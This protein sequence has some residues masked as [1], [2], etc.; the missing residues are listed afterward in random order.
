MPYKCI[1][2]VGT[3]F[4]YNNPDHIKNWDKDWYYEEDPTKH[5]EPTDVHGATTMSATG[6]TPA[7]PEFKT[8]RSTIGKKVNFAKNYGAQK[9]R[10]RQM[11]P[12]CTEAEVAKIDA[13]YYN[14][15]PG[16][17][18]YHNYCYGRANMYSYTENLFGVKYYG[19]N[20]HKLINSLVQGS[21]AFYLKKKIR[22]VYDY[23]KINKIQST[24]QMNIHDELSWEVFDG[25]EPN[26]FEIKRIMEDWTDA[27][28]PIVA[29][30]DITNKT[31][32]DKKGVHSLEDIYNY[33]GN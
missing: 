31:W 5:W 4:D 2:N 18:E 13:S 26:F 1:N 16:V 28:V 10:I 27:L 14:T 21:A 22:E 20:G 30:M 11:F 17:K 25:E 8:L 9:G 24:F 19:V 32:D 12:E 29:E 3:L 15:F 23:F 6:L 7:D 33:L